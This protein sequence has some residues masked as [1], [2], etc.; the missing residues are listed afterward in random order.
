MKSK[1]KRIT[2]KKT[3][4]SNYR[5]KVGG[6]AIAA[7]GYGCV[8]KPALKCK[9]S[10]SR[11]TDGVTKVLLNSYADDEINEITNVKRI[12]E[13]IPNY[14]EYFLGLDA[15]KCDLDTLTSADKVGFD[16]KCKNLK[17]HSIDSANVNM[18]LDKIKGINLPY[19]GLEL[20]KFLIRKKLT[21]DVFVNINNALIKLLKNGLS[22]MNKL[23]L[24]HFDLKGSN[25]LITDDY[26]ARIIDWGLSGSQRANE[27]PDVIKTRPFM[28]NAPFSVSVF[29]STFEAYVKKTISEILNNIGPIHSLNEIRSDI[30]VYMI[31]W[32]YKFMNKGG[33]GHYEYLNYIFNN[34]LFVSYEDFPMNINIDSNPDITPIINY[35][36]LNT[37]MADEL[38]EV[39][40]QYTSLDGDFNTERYFNNA[41]K[42]NVDI[43]GLL[44]CY[45]DDVIHTISDSTYNS[46]S[47]LD[48]TTLLYGI[49][50]IANKYMFNGKQLV[51]PISVDMLARDLKEL[52]N[53]FGHARTP[54]PIARVS[55]PAPVPVPAP[56]TSIR[57][58]P[59]SSADPR[60]IVFS[61]SK[62]KT[63]SRSP[64]GPVAPP[65]K[66]RKRNVFC[67]EDKKRKCASMGKVC[68]E[69]T[70]R[71]NKP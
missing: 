47:K 61:S 55:P 29:D 31:K 56:A 38:T 19:G 42:Y 58:P 21:P 45:L 49:R 6:A 52:N 9:G 24:F 43:W 7:G 26:K 67:D 1:S 12:I 27:L 13:R 3:G 16:T 10:L 46:L 44:T 68:N 40:I 53:I 64:V 33:K 65:K 36:F 39:V 69:A 41:F 50:Q 62:S 17:K 22:P 4:K 25:I 2:M 59:V 70:G 20:G 14:N 30:K 57:S 35:S 66:T 60:A 18:N 28:Y 11:T 32:I 34:L 71:C 63:R 5:S 37:F 23:K 8:F 54:S 15:V 48:S 51:N